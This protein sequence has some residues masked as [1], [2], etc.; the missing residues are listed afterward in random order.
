MII[1]VKYNTNFNQG[2]IIHLGSRQVSLKTIYDQELYSLNIIAFMIYESCAYTRE[3]G[4][5]FPA[6][7]PFPIEHRYKRFIQQ[8]F[9]PY[10]NSG[11]EPEQAAARKSNLLSS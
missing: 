1:A 10:T 11:I 6:Y 8:L 2:I 9:L 7:T 5:T 3:Q 4:S